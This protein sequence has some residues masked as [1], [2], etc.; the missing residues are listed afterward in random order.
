[1]QNRINLSIQLPK[2]KGSLLDTHADT[3]NGNSPF[4]IVV[5]VPLVDCY[6]TK[7]MYTSLW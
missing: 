2:D 7:S 6:K 5:W 4:E 1:M 3:W